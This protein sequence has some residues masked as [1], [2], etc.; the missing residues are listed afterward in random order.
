MDSAC[1]VRQHMATVG[2]SR[3]DSICA[4]AVSRAGTGESNRISP[5]GSSKYIRTRIGQEI[6]RSDAITDG[7]FLTFKCG[8]MY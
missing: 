7:F 5:C 2:R 6:R 1:G 4:D 8:G 3:N